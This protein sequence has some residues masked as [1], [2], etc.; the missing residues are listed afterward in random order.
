MVDIDGA[1]TYKK[2]Y[3]EN[4]Y[5]TLTQICNEKSKSP[6]ENEANVKT[7]KKNTQKN[8]FFVFG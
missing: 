5:D 3:M 8:Y 4:I 6:S 7:I 2:L 1:N